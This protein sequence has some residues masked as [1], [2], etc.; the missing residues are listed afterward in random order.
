MPPTRQYVGEFV[1][2]R[3]PL[4]GPYSNPAIQEQVARLHRLVFPDRPGL[5][6]AHDGR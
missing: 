5:N 2:V 4:I 1:K 3:V 6:L